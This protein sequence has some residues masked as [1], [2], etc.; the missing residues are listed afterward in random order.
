[1]SVFLLLIVIGFFFYFL[2]ALVASHR[3]NPN[4]TAIFVLNLLLGWS[5]IGW[6]V[7]L[8]WAFSGE[9]RKGATKRRLIYTCPYCSEEVLPTAIKCKHCASEL[10]PTATN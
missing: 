1:M 6:V 7:A 4:A 9:N 10:E 5:V 3:K 8:V 2:P